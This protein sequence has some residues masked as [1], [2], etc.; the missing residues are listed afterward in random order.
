M[1]FS[2]KFSIPIVAQTN[3]E[4]KDLTNGKSLNI[5]WKVKNKTKLKMKSRKFFIRPI[6]TKWTETNEMR[7]NVKDGFCHLNYKFMN[8]TC[9]ITQSCHIFIRKSQ[10][11]FFFLSDLVRK[12]CAHKWRNIRLRSQKKKRAY[13]WS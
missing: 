5:E 9:Q 13:V 4:I 8:E 10:W 3:L 1:I 7:A 12:K 6:W 2:V 11:F